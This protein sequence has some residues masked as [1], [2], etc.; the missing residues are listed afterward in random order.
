MIGFNV[1]GKFGRLGNQMFQFASLKG[2]AKNNN[3][4]YCIPPI[5]H[6]LFNCFKF[7]STSFLNFQYIDAK[8]PVVLETDFSFDKSLFENCPDWVDIRGYF[9]SEKYFIHIKDELLKD[10]EFIDGILDPAKDAI[11][12]WKTPVSLHIR[13]TDYISNPNH[14]VL[15]MSYYER[16]LSYF[17]S[18]STILIFSDEPEWCMKHELFSD[19]RFL[20]SE[21]ENSYMD[22]CLMTL[23]SGHIIANSSFSWWGAWLSESEK[24]IAPKDWFKG[25]NNE[26]LDTKDLIPNNWIIL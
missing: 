23:C 13:R 19:D 3:Y 9:Q 20:V 10:F 18:N 2:I 4:Q 21:T 8:R 12:N 26:H 1:L 24:V 15:S 14:S 6:D 11:K 5:G 25:S 22:L 17:N 7:N 16:A